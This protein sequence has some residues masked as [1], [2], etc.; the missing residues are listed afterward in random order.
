MYSAAFWSFI[1]EFTTRNPNLGLPAL[2]EGLFANSL[3]FDYLTCASTYRRGKVFQITR[4]GVGA[5]AIGGAYECVLP[6][7][8]NSFWFGDTVEL[9]SDH[10]KSIFFPGEPA[11]NS[12]SGYK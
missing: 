12:L 9:T 10:G 11:S 8:N 5:G 2:E 6:R 4:A 3:I 7:Q 1:T